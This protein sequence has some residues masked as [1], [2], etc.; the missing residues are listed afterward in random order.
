MDGGEVKEEEEEEED[1]RDQK[2]WQRL[3]EE[4][5]SIHVLIVTGKKTSIRGASME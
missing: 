5:L 3:Q 1:K 4:R 2:Q